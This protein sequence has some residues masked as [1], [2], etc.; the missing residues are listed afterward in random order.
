MDFLNSLNSTATY[1]GFMT[2]VAP[3]YTSGVW[4][5]AVFNTPAA[6]ILDMDTFVASSG[7]KYFYIFF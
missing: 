7:Q 1:S 5:H 4:N 2:T 6:V 3:V